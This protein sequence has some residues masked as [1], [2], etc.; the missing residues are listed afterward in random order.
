AALAQRYQ[1]LGHDLAKPELEKAYKLFTKLCDVKKEVFEEDLVAILRDGLSDIPETWK[2]RLA[3]VTAGTQGYSHALVQLRS[4]EQ[5]LSGTGHGDGPV[6]ALVDAIAGLTSIRGEVLDFQ[7]RAVSEGSDAVGEVFMK[8][9]IEGSL[10]TGKAASTDIIEGAARA[11]LNAVN[12][13]LQARDLKR[14]RQAV[15]A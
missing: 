14:S 2:L 13:A 10:L 15:T 12:K 7:V 4:G 1:E 8:V 11:Y 9:E 6:A 3:Q 5:E